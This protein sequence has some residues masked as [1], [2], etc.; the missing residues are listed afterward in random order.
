MDSLPEDY[1]VTSMQFTKHVY[2]DT[3]PSIDPTSPALSQKG[4][5]IIITGASRGL[6]ARAFV[7]SFAKAGAKAIVLVARDPERLKT[8]EAEFKSSYPNTHFLSISCDVS[9]E[10]SVKHLFAKVE[11]AF[12]HANVLV[13]NAGVLQTGGN[14]KDVEGAAW[15]KEMTLNSYGNF[16]VTQYFLKSTPADAKSTI[17]S[18]TTGAAHQVYPGLS[19]YALS[20]LVVLLSQFSD[21]NPALRRAL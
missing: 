16:L 8:A 13:N 12:G 5:V 17:I 20:K 14:V 1:F 19:A 7:P 2:R 15:W 10:E 18:L 6:G 11:E 4:K 21:P 3:Y 9:D